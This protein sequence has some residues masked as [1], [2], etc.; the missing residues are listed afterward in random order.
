VLE[1]SIKRDGARSRGEEAFFAMSEPEFWSCPKGAPIEALEWGDTER[2]MD[3]P[4]ALEIVARVA[5]LVELE[6][7]GPPRHF[8]GLDGADRAAR[9]ASLPGATSE[10]DL[11]RS[12]KNS[13]RAKAA[14]RRALQRI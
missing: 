9:A 14:A 1:L 2:L 3:D 7:S 8:A 12:R 5:E 13:A 11:R 6:N 10:N 4:A